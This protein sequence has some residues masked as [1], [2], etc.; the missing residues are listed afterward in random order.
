MNEVYRLQRAIHLHIELQIKEEMTSNVV[1]VDLHDLQY[2]I[3]RCIRF[4]EQMEQMEEENWNIGVERD[5]P[6]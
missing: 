6:T 1:C 4:E 3:N 5:L 2:L